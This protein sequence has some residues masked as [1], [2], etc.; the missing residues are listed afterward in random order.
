[1]W[2]VGAKGATEL[3]HSIVTLLYGWMASLS[4]EYDETV[5]QIDNF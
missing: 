3:V 1:M 2:G 4:E 5:D